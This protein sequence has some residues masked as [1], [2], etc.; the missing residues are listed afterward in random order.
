MGR[1]GKGAANLFGGNGPAMARRAPWWGDWAGERAM[2]WAR[3][4]K[5]VTDR[6]YI[7]HVIV[8]MIGARDPGR[9]YPYHHYPSS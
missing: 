2:V 4:A 7:M 5:P 6:V 8:I 9:E 1:A 3:D